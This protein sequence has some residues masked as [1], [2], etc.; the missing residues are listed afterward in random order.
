ML[1]VSPGLTRT[2][3]LQLLT[4]PGWA[5]SGVGTPLAALGTLMQPYVSAWSLSQAVPTPLFQTTKSLVEM[6]PLKKDTMSHVSPGWIQTNL[7][8][9]V[10]ILV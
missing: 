5:G 4:M 3:F 2:N 6:G 7:L 9:L 8:Q 10:A 1:H